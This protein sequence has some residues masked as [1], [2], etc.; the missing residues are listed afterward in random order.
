MTRLRSFAA[1]LALLV[2]T[3]GCGLTGLVSPASPGPS[4]ASSPTITGPATMPPRATATPRPAVTTAPA[5]PRPAAT[6]GPTATPAP[7]PTSAPGTPGPTPTPR[8]PLAIRILAAGARA[9]A[10][11][12]D[13]DVARLVKGSTDF[14]LDLLARV[15][16]SSGDA[17]VALGPS[18]IS[19]AFGLLHAGARGQTATQIEQVMGFDL[20]AARL[21]AAANTLDQALQ[22]RQNKK[23]ELD[24]VN[25]LFGQDGY[26]FSQ[27]YLRTAARQFGAPLA[28][29]D[30]ERKAAAVTKLI[31]TWIAD[32]TNGH[33]TDVIPPDTLDASTRLVLANATYLKAEWAQKFE[34]VFTSPRPFTRLDGTAVKVPMMSQS[35]HFPAAFTPDY[36]AVEL[37]YVGDKL[38]MLIVMPRKPDAFLAGLDA[39]G[40]AAIVDGLKTSFRVRGYTFDYVDLKMPRWS[41]R[42]NVGLRP[43]LAKMGM[44]DVWQPGVAD[45]TGIADPTVTGE[46]PLSASAATHEAWIKVTEKGTEAAAVTVIDLGTGGGI[47]IPPPSVNLDHPFLWFIRD[48]ETGAI[49]FAGRVTD[50]SVTAD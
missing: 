28:T 30:F 15:I 4:V 48:R 46:A 19:A 21:N 7:P 43:L 47:D 25:Q 39:D 33:I 34:K 11:A 14:A 23:V 1:L 24:I 22:S 9:A 13:A 45:L 17:N 10:G 41:T 26:P 6:A 3:S 31:N 16:R 36:T 29:V 20:P 18:S 49:L 37:P 2:V 32:H 38:A 5:T 12:P 42:T 40:L 27:A 8:P 44:T 50:P 35:A